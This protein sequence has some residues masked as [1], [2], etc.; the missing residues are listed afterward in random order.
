MWDLHY[1]SPRAP[2]YD[3]PIS[4]IPGDTPRGP[5]GAR[6]LPGQY[7]VKLTVNGKSYDEPLTIKMDPRVKTSSEGLAQM[8]QLESR[9]AALMTDASRALA[10]ARSAREQLQKLNA[11]QGGA[12]ATAISDFGKKLSAVLDGP[13]QA[14]SPT[15]VGVNGGISALYG[16]L[17]RADATPTKAQHDAMSEIEVGFG[18]VMKAWSALTKTDLPALNQQLR[19]AN[20]P[21]VRLEA[22]PQ[23]EEDP[24]DL[25]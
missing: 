1:P 12:L 9:L 6:A 8:F 10:G 18:G 17:D 24:A 23:G 21:E 19:Q 20:L 14:G 3:Y 15:L 22:E 11:P 2:R 16:E 5:L 7:A 4:A 25:E 13:G